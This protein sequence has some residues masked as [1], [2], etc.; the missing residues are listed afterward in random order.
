MKELKGHEG[1]VTCLR[2]FLA[3]D[4]AFPA[5]PMAPCASGTPRVV[6]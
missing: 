1:A 3:A 5:A 4:E 2:L 6:K